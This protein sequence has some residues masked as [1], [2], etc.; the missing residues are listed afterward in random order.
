MD[1]K[2]IP[3]LL[4]LNTDRQKFISG[5]A[6]FKNG[7]VFGEYAKVEHTTATFYANVKDAYHHQ[8][9]TCMAHINSLRGTVE[10]SCDCQSAVSVT[11]RIMLCP[12]VVAT[13][14]KGLKSVMQE[15]EEKSTQE[16]VIY[17]P[18]VT[19]CMLPGRKGLMKMEFNLEG[20][21]KSEYRKI[22]NAYKEN[23][24]LY[25]FQDGSCL[26]LADDQLQAT[27]K[28]I[29]LLG[30][31]N[32]F[33]DLRIPY[34]KALYLDAYMKEH[35]NFVEGQRFISQV[36]EKIKGQQK[37]EMV[38]PK[39]LKAHLRDYQ[40]KGFEFLNSLA[41]YGFGGI[42]ADEMG[43]GKTL[44]VI[45]FLLAHQGQ[46]SLV[47]MPTALLYNWK[48]EIEKFAPD[49]K[50]AV[51]HGTKE[52]SQI[53]N[54]YEAYDVLLT[55]YTTFKNDAALYV[56]KVFD[57]CIIDEA[58]T[59]KNPDATLTKV[60]K[61]IKAKVKFALTGTPIE[62]NLL[63][64]W[65]IFDFVMPDYLYTRAKF[66]KIFMSK[67]EQHTELKQL[68]KP[69]MLR[70]T[71][72][73]VA[74]ELPDKI[75]QVYY[76]PLEKEHEY[77]YHAYRQ[78]AKRKMQEDESAGFMAF[79]YLTK[80]RQL[81]LAPEWLVKHYEGKN[82][83]LEALIGLIKAST[84]KK[85]LVFSQF[86]KVLGGIAHR[87]EQENIVYSYL[88]GSTPAAKRIQMVE[89]FNANEQ[90]QVFL[91][92][93]K[94]GGTGLNL[95]SANIVVHFDPWWNPAVENQATDRAHR[96]GQKEVVNVVKLIAKGTV[97]ERVLQLQESKKELIDAIMTDGLN[98]GNLLKHLSKEE[99][100]AFFMEHI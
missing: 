20:I 29:D 23:K 34:E 86:T 79:S 35:M 50:V 11:N 40:E 7:Q 25:R 67:D 24:K 81:A 44:Q 93:L 64:L 55:T 4:K 84:G 69:F 68:I 42:L 76:V 16:G 65:S 19:V 48:K 88:D 91:I 39:N 13:V 97:E 31:F 61:S 73:E 62:N 37:I 72:K 90:Q 100:I 8:H 1:L 21:E 41:S 22:Y 5:Q 27:F 30:L 45:T 75:E 46:K 95:T 80:L 96:I 87:L 59:I 33:E 98:K 51:V 63:E 36:V 92:S 32:D 94:A 18:N 38:V 28:L 54:Q 57:Y 99:L 10:A 26:D 83:K 9:Y 89:A 70:R 78:L 74:K 52:R 53:I 66:Q 58:Q 15:G 56:G 47:I 85:I 6:L 17:H 43:L 77:V 60:I 2:R 3:E 82:S 12:H 71:K 49:I 14:L